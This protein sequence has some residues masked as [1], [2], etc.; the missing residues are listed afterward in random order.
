MNKI[1]LVLGV[2]ALATIVGCKDADYK[3]R[4][5]SGPQNQVTTV[6][7]APDQAPAAKKCACAPGTKHTAPCTCGAPDCAC[8]VVVEKKC[9][10]A[11]GTKHTAPCTCGAPTCACVVV[12]PAP[13]PE[14]TTYVVQSGDYLAKISKKFNVTIAGIRKLNPSIKGDVIRVGQRINLPGRI[15]VAA[16][17]P[18]VSKKPVPTR[19]SAKAPAA[20][21]G[22]TKDYVVRAGDTLGAIAYGNGITIR[23]LKQLNGLTTRTVRVGQKLKIPA[24]P[25]AKKAKPAAEKKPQPTKSVAKKADVQPAEAAQQPAEPAGDKKPA[26]AADDAPVMEATPTNA[27]STNAPAAAVKEAPAA[28]APATTKYVVQEGDDM[29]SVSISWGVSAAAIRELNN[30]GENDQLKPGQVIKLPADTEQ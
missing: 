16:T 21:K 25:V 4:R 7:T 2:A 20:Y 6:P 26:A 23:Q 14:T 12:K 8:V 28:P 30:L 22:E 9:T 5:A 13:A 29:T 19:A 27:A 1:G 3:G 11:P 24:K 17:A 10:C 18:A 15:P